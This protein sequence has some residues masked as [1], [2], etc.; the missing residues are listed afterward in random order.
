MSEYKDNLEPP[1]VKPETREQQILH[2]ELRRVCGKLGLKLSYP[3]L[4]DVFDRVKLGYQMDLCK[5][6]GLI[7]LVKR[8]DM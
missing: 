4:F 5:R 8:N 3:E 1:F 7:K 2:N 6:M